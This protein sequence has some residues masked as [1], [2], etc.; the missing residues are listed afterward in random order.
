MFQQPKYPFEIAQGT[1]HPVAKI[2]EPPV[3]FFLPGHEHDCITSIRT[4]KSFDGEWPV[5]TDVRCFHCHHNFS[6]TP[7]GIPLKR[8]LKQAAQIPDDKRQTKLK[9]IYTCSGCYCSFECAKANLRPPN[10]PSLLMLLR[11]DACGISMKNPDG[12]PNSIIAAPPFTMLREYGGELSIEEFRSYTRYNDTS[13]QPCVMTAKKYSIYS[14]RR[15]SKRNKR[16][17]KKE[18]ISVKQKSQQLSMDIV[19][20][21]IKHDTKNVQQGTLNAFII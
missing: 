19:M 3:V 10:D 15:V 18:D 17:A 4:L 5:K 13:I 16:A 7:V 14:G 9:Y 11:H 12:S 21:N 2:E 6:T 8:Q 20:N 1:D